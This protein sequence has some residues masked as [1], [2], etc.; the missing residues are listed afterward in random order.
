MKLTAINFSLIPPTGNTYKKEKTQKNKSSY[1]SFGFHDALA[2]Y[3]WSIAKKP[4]HGGKENSKDQI[5]GCPKNEGKFK[6][7]NTKVTPLWVNLF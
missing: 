4:V 1:I 5:E 7:A 2:F 6:M 3:L